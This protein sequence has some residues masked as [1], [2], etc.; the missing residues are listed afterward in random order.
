M[1]CSQ[2][3][4]SWN[5]EL[6]YR[7]DEVCRIKTECPVEEREYT[8]DGAKFIYDTVNHHYIISLPFLKEVET[9]PKNRISII[10][11]LVTFSHSVEVGGCLWAGDMYYGVNKTSLVLKLTELEKRIEALGG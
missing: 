7:D 8:K 4:L 5:S 3:S 9:R 2:L 1:D 11:H 10:S 6:V